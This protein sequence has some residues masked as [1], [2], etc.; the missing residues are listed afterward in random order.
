LDQEELT[1]RRVVQLKPKFSRISFVFSFS[2]AT[3]FSEIVLS[4][5]QPTCHWAPRANPLI[6]PSLIARLLDSQAVKITCAERNCSMI[7]F[8]Y[9]GEIRVSSGPC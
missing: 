7:A 1:S 5:E 2:S 9:V 4:V 6:L 8:S 3:S